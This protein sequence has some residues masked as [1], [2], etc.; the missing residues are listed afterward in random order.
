MGLGIE[1]TSTLQGLYVAVSSLNCGLSSKSRINSPGYTPCIPPHKHPP[2]TPIMHHSPCSS[3][4]QT[5]YLLVVL[6]SINSPLSQPTH[7]VTNST[8]SYID[9]L[10]NPDILHSLHQQTSYSNPSSPP[11]TITLLLPAID[12]QSSSLTHLN[13]SSHHCP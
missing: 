8:L 12:F 13:K 11:N 3:D 1:Q 5:S 4:I 2:Y 9:P 7:W 6:H 10:S